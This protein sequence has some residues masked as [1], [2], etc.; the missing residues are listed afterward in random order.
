MTTV[1][2]LIGLI[3][4]WKRKDWGFPGMVLATGCTFYSGFEDLLFDLEN[5][6]LVPFN[7]SSVVELVAVLCSLAMPAIVTILLWKQRKE[8][9]K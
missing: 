3:G 9:I 7:G 4:L 8:L 6:L 1:A 2:A 5:H